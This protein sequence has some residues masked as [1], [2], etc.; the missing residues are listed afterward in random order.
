[1]GKMSDIVFYT[2]YSSS[3]VALTTTHGR[4][5]SIGDTATDLQRE[6]KIDY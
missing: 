4:T 1:M 3:S 5:N 6:R 2:H